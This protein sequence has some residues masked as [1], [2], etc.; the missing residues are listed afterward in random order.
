MAYR[1]LY[2]NDYLTDR[3]RKNIILLDV[4]RRNGPIAK[5][6]ISRITQF[7]IV[8]VSNYVE[9]YIDQKLVIEKGLD[10]SSGGRRPELIELNADWGNLVGVE[11]GPTHILGFVTNLTP[12]IIFKEKTKRPEGHMEVVIAEAVK[13]V[14][15][16]IEGSKVPVEKIKGIG[17]GIS[18]VIDK[19]AG[20]IRD[21]DS[22]RGKT[23][24][25][26][27]TA[28]AILEK[29]FKVPVSVGNDANLAAL[30]EKK[31]SLRIDDE[32]VLYFY[33]DVGT[34]IIANN[35]LFWGSSWSAGEVQLNLDNRDG[36]MLAPWVDET[37][38]FK[39]EGLDLGICRR[40]REAMKK[41][42]S[43]TK[44][45]DLCGKNLEK[46]D[47][48]MI[49]EAAKA[50][51]PFAMKAVEEGCT[52]LGLKVAYLT[53]FFNPEVVVLGG[54]VEKG[55]ELVLNV[56]RRVV[57]QLVMEEAAGAVK[58]ILSRLGED[59]VAYG[60]VCLVTQELFAEV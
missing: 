34:G 13:L 56:V 9:H 44:L 8:T 37:D 15:N 28:K 5:T 48:N 26:Y 52:R 40:V 14:R 31:Q 41:E 22:L 47:M 23:V 35:D 10:I 33:S 53:N 11:I 2:K 54:G 1:S 42:T 7:N 60:A 17:L 16:I 51:D 45:W 46:M 49:F 38:F 12:S 39:S 24:G 6:D 27:A 30:A 3:E 32:N 36:L 59:A 4:I 25:S 29:E 43:K 58:I 50:N 18:G 19:N 20:T 21:T 57:K 55:G